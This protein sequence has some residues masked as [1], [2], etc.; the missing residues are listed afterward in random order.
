MN[1]S[2]FMTPRLLAVASF[3]KRESKVCDVGTDHAYIP[4]WLIKNGVSVSALA[5]D[6]NEGPLERAKENIEKFD[7]SEKVKTRLS[8]GLCK[9]E[10]NEADT[11]IIAGMGGILINR[12]LE[13]A[14]E[15]LPGIKHFVLQPMTAIEETRKFLAEN[16]L[17]I[18]DEKLVREEDKIYTVLSVTHGKMDVKDD[19]Y[20]YVGEKLIKN[21]DELLKDY[22][23]GKIYELN[24]AINSMVNTKNKEALKKRVFFTEQKAKMEKI[25]EECEKW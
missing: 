23:D 16:S 20:Y 1:V 24:K 10:K 15:L 4:I 2:K 25:R 8:D 9:L 5:M 6:I 3:V 13:N 12:I 11:V 7:M 22:L 17:L 21:R 19:I 18:E 14:K